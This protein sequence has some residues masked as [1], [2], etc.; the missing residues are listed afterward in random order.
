VVLG[1]FTSIVSHI[2]NTPDLGDVSLKQKFMVRNVNWY[3]EDDAVIIQGR[4]S[5]MNRSNTHIEAIYRTSVTND[6]NSAAE[7]GLY[8]GYASGPLGCLDCFLGIYFKHLLFFNNVYMYI[9]IYIGIK[10]GALRRASRDF[11]F[12]TSLSL[13]FQEIINALNGKSF[14]LPKMEMGVKKKDLGKKGLDL[15]TKYEVGRSQDACA[16]ELHLKEQHSKYDNSF[17]VRVRTGREMKSVSVFNFEGL[18]STS[19]YDQA[20]MTYAIDFGEEK[21]WTTKYKISWNAHEV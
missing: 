10:L 2:Y 16:L 12:S 4:M 20:S 9:Y 1:K 13:D 17:K 18:R 15:L 5:T 7:V 6:C 3:N 11:L 8:G 19:Y 14:L 21:A